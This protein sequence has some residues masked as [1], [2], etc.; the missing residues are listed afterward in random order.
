MA[1]DAGLIISARS[2]SLPQRSGGQTTTGIG[3]S[4]PGSGNGGSSG[5]APSSGNL[6]RSCPSNQTPKFSHQLSSKNQKQK[7]QKKRNAQHRQ[8]KKNKNV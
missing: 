3:E 4:N 1:K 5:S 6:N 8:K 7:K 2:P